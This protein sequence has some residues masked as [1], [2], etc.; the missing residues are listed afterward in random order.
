MKKFMYMALSAFALLACSEDAQNVGGTSEDPNT[1][2]LNSSSSSVPSSY[3]PHYVLCRLS[4]DDNFTKPNESDACDWYAEMWNPELGYRV[5]TGF[6]N[7]TNTSGIWYWT[8]DSTE[9]LIPSIRWPAEASGEYDSLALSGVIDACHGELCGKTIISPINDGQHHSVSDYEVFGNALVSLGFSVAGKNASGKFDEA[10][11]SDLNGICIGY[12]TNS[13]FHLVLDFS[14]SV[15]ALMGQ[16]SYEAYLVRST[17]Y[18]RAVDTSY[19]EEC[20]AWSDFRVFNLFD[21]SGSFNQP[22][23]SITVQ[24]AVKHLVGIR[25]VFDSYYP[26]SAIFRI[27]RM[28]WYSEVDNINRTVEYSLPVIDEDCESPIVVEHFCSCNYADSI[29]IREGTKSGYYKAVEEVQT[30]Y[31]NSQRYDHCMADLGFEFLAEML[32]DSPSK[33]KPCDNPENKIVRCQDGSYRF[34]EE[35]S[36]IKSGFDSVLDYAMMTRKL[37]YLHDMDSCVNPGLY[38]VQ[39]VSS[40]SYVPYDEAYDMVRDYGELWNFYRNENVQTSL[41]ADSTWPENVDNGGAWFYETDSAKGGHS[42]AVWC[43][44]SDYPGW[45]IEAMRTFSGELDYYIEYDE[46]QRN[47]KPYGD[48]GFYVAGFDSNGNALPADISNWNG[49]CLAYNFDDESARL[50]LII[51]LGD[52]VNRDLGYDL[53]SV[54]LPVTNN[55]QTA[56]FNWSDFKQDGRGKDVEGY[57][58]SITGEEAARKAV[59][60]YFRIQSIYDNH[61]TLA[62]ILDDPPPPEETFEYTYTL[63][64]GITGLS[65]NRN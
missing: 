50:N 35:F 31:G 7:G 1:L 57:K 63:Y 15:N 29:A 42:T 36:S 56:C 62:D 14:D 18:D 11:V 49:I 38:P 34:A 24:E 8:F 47:P 37:K 9:L 61:E 3:S 27:V 60:I 39:E 22:T 52:S 20:F 41:Y 4:A 45:S 53:P 59:K 40:S 65:A 28:G 25:I 64:F 16:T 5:R 51:D 33:N 23:P 58:Y 21:M 10:D 43:L 55:Y 17:Q 6:D 44:D 26:A 48:I 2:A 32:G 46:N 19:R 13:F 30:K 54:E 12:S